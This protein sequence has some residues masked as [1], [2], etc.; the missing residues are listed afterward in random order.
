M[1]AVQTEGRTVR[2]MRGG[3]HLTLDGVAKGR[4]VDL[5]SETLA[6]HGVRDHLIDAGGDIRV[7]GVPEPDR[8]WQVAVR[9]PFDGTAGERLRLPAK[10]FGAVATSGGY[11]V[12]YDPEHQYTHLVDPRTG[13]SPRA[14]ASVTVMAPTVR[15]ADGLATALSVMAPVQALRLVE[16]L[17]ECECLLIDAAG[18]RHP[19]SG[20]PLA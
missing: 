1:D 4:I 15:A 6:A 18:T 10:R 3:M 14:L 13:L 8:D 9:D 20:L 17:P 19:S 12:F 16:S 11:E 2:L 5:A 7:Q